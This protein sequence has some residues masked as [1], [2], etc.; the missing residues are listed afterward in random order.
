MSKLLT[1]ILTIAICS[2]AAVGISNPTLTPEVVYEVELDTVVS[3]EA[4]YDTTGGNDSDEIIVKT[5]RFNDGGYRYMLHC[6]TITGTDVATCSLAI[7]IDAYGKSDSL[8]SS[9]IVDSIL[10]ATDTRKYLDFQYYPGAKHSVKL[11][12][13]GSNGAEIILNEIEI[14][15]LRPVQIMKRW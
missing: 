6:G 9:N 13:A 14:Y 7:R 2:Y 4:N 5:K 15:K 10:T 11:L 12:G 1:A 8:L 3:N